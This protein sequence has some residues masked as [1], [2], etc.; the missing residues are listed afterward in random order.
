MALSKAAPAALQ[1]P[2][3]MDEEEEGGGG[4]SPLQIYLILVAYWKHAAIIAVSIIAVGALAIKL[5]PKSYTATAVLKVDSDVSDPLAGQV[6]QLDQRGSYIPTEMQ[7][8][9]SDD[10]LRGVIDQLQLTTNKDY[11]AGFRGPDS[12]ASRREWVKERLLKD[13]D[14]EQGTSGSLLINVTA[15]ASN[16]VLAAD[17]ANAVADTYLRQ[18]RHRI[19]DPA[20]ERVKRYSEQ[21]AELKQKIT[22]AADQ[23]AAFKQRTGITDP[24]GAKNVE[25]ETLTTMQGRLED[26]RNARREAEVRAASNHSAAQETS[27]ARASVEALQAQLA[28]QQ[29]QLAQLRTTL[30]PEHPKVLELESA[31][32]ATRKTI[33]EQ[34]QTF[35]L[36]ADADLAAARQLERKLQD[37][38]DEQRTKVLAA[39]GIQ[40]E[41]NKYMLELE[42]A[43]SVYKRALD[44]YDQIMFA[45]TGHYTFVDLVS[46]AVP[47]LKSTKPN[48]LKLLVMNVLVALGLGLA[49]PLSYELFFNRR[50]RCRD[51][52]E[53]E[54]RV[55]VLIELDAI[56]ASARPA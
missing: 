48:K 31:M 16:P 22:V 41:G 46:R 1:L 26:A 6:N 47:P 34:M 5:L 45:S 49:A 51:D 56:G 11:I 20:S 25:V 18:E 44:G 38:V 23:V 37:A 9:A 53:R 33:A 55:P 28:T 50:V 10:V 36:S 15:T 2:T 19:D 42:S 35:S 40:D 24:T 21:L 30:G 17:I 8:M 12:P 32:R 14:I 7:L 3:G 4:L 52:L 54:F 43:Q 39:G 29:T 13:L 27:K